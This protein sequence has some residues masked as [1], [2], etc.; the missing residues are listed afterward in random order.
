MTPS[1]DATRY[2]LHPIV[3]VDDESIVLRGY[4]IVLLGEGMDNLV[5]CSSAR[6]ALQT[7]RTQHASVVVT[8]LWMPEL[9]GEKLLEEIKKDYPDIPVIVVTGANEVET[10][11]RCMRTGAADYIVKPVD[12]PRL[13]AS[14]RQAMEHAELKQQYAML[15]EQLFD[16]RLR[17]PEAFT[18]IIT[19]SANM[20]AIFQYIETIGPARQPVLVTGE[21][22]TGK[23][24]IAQVIH[25][26]S[27]R[28]GEFVA[29]NVAGF[30]ETIFSDALFGHK[31]GAYTGAD[32]DRQGLIEKAAG[33]TLFLDEIGEMNA[34]SQVKLLRLLQEREYYPLGSDV[35][36]LSDARM[37]FAT[38][39]DVKELESS[40]DFRKDLYYRL[41]A[42]H[43]NLPPLRDRRED[44]PP[45]VQHFMEEAA[46][47]LGGGICPLSKDF[48]EQ[49]KAHSF[50][51]N[52]RELRATVFDY[53]SRQRAGMTGDDTEG[54]DGEGAPDSAID[55]AAWDC[56]SLF[57]SLD[58]LPTMDIMEDVLL[59]EA[60]RRAD[61]NKSLAAD[62][63]GITRQTLHKR[64][65]KE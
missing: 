50:P 42:Y 17:H 13:A 12:P 39:R 3:L 2:P 25:Q 64:T 53:L 51:G 19:R 47:E 40:P 4:R 28:K 1:E 59:E 52:I 26:L 45:L 60:L 15:K 22:G 8:D 7:L 55:L 63:L 36:R 16:K 27:G 37:V 41:K 57:S 49:L 10:A 18:R 58:Q 21:T 46:R 43:V 24:L 62:M 54:E 38:N 61:G 65:K 31:K 23:E 48:Q 6:E 5:S 20:H 11:V 32:S 44:I 14:V 29:V 56:M 34:G 9:S 30:D 33:G 35:A